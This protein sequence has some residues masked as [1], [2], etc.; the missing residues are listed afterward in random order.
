MAEILCKSKEFGM[1]MR[2]WA[3]INNLFYSIQD[4]SSKNIR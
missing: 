1:M 2:S 4:M 3:T